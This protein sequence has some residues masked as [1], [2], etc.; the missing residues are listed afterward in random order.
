MADF[1]ST[2]SLMNRI[3]Q[4]PELQI[5]DVRR[6][7][8]YEAATHVISG[9]TWA[10]PDDVDVWKASLDKQRPTVVYCAHGHAVS[11]GC[12]NTLAQAGFDVH[13]LEGG[14]EQ[15]STEGKPVQSKS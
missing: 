12:A 6:R 8:A 11:Q 15:W 9:A 7:A 5:I 4:T 13:Y 14:F 1:V 10:S 3:G 2:S